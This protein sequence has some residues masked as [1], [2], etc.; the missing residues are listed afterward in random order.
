[1]PPRTNAELSKQLSMFES[2]I[3]NLNVIILNQS[4]TI[5][6]LNITNKIIMDELD[7]IENNIKDN[8]KHINRHFIDQLSVINNKIIT[9]NSLD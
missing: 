9:S 6:S 3:A 8:Q 2:T 5:E 4:K 1:M 7:C